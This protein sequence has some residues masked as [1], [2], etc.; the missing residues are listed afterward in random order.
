MNMSDY[1]PITIILIAIIAI[2]AILYM[3]ARLC[4][5]NNINSREDSRRLRCIDED[6]N[7]HVLAKKRA[8]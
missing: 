4:S 7:W 5:M 8:G 2:V 3:T 1:I 6:K